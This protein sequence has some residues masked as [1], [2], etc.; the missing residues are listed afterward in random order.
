MKEEGELVV[1]D[2]SVQ[3]N[4]ATAEGGGISIVRGTAL[5]ET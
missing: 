4:K 1:A 5:V 2:S 3:D